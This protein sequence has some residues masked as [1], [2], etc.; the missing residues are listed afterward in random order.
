MIN[1][2]KVISTG[3]S[4]RLHQE[5]LHQTLKR[6]NVLVCHRRFGKTTLC[7]NELVDRALRNQ[8]KNP[9]YAYI[10][11]TYGQAKRVAWDMFKQYTNQIP[12][13]SYNE[14]ELRVE[15]QRA[16]L[17][18]KIKIWLLGAE[19]PGSLRGIYLD[20]VILDE[21]AEM[22][23]GIW[24]EVIRPALSDRKGWAIFIGT[25]KGQNHFYDV[26]TVAQ[27]NQTGDW[28]QSIYKASQ[29]GIVDK[30]ELDAARLEMDEAEYAQEFECS[31]SAA[32]V[33]SYYGKLI[34]EADQEGRITN[35]PYDR[36]LPVDTYWDLGIG[37]SMAIWFVQPYGTGYRAIDYIEASGE[38]LEHYAQELKKRKYVYRTHYWPHDGEARDLS[39]GKTR[40]QTWRSL[41]Y[42]DTIILPRLAVEDGIHAARLVIPKCWFDVKKCE[43][44]I[45]ALRNYQKR[46]DAKNKIFVQKPLHNWAS[47]GA[48]AFRTFALGCQDEGSV[49]DKKKLPRQSETDYKILGGR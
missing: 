5:L 31:F 45:A 27:K 11:P 19:N 1:E 3:Y 42:K 33:G 25:P 41:G 38:G 22:H 18:D 28:F 20:G 4:P 44:G 21:Y 12:G 34:E 35:V 49:R 46:W 23:P 48:D 47:H 15:I 10:A 13:I 14:A 7:V 26:Y 6:F 37:D 30:A 24:G 8:E 16:H 29:T 2:R 43:R 17:G 39:T 36:A 40:I 32:L 9:Q